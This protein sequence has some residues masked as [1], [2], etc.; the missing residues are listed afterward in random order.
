MAMLLIA[1]CKSDSEK[2]RLMF[3]EAHSLMRQEKTAEA[4]KKLDEL[5]TKFGHTKEATEASQMLMTLK[6]R[7][8]LG[9]AKADETWRNAILTALAT[10]MLDV[11]RFPT[12][13][14]GL[15]VLLEGKG[16]RNW[17]GP[18]WKAESSAVLNRFEYRPSGTA[19]PY[20][21][22]KQGR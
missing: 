3:N 13:D 15:R 17:N 8:D 6:F 11:G 10:F 1:G 16:I 19:E 9:M 7:D 21:S 5:V 14:E 12:A 2:A 4:K 22:L 18:Y 20:V